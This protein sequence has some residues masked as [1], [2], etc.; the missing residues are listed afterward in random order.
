MTGNHPEDTGAQ[1]SAI[2]ELARLVAEVGDPDIAINELR[3]AK[4]GA[5]IEV[6][7]E[8]TLVITET[9]RRTAEQ[10]GA[11]TRHAVG[12]VIV[13]ATLRGR[14]AQPVWGAF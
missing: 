9:W 8:D 2:Q 7:G 10:V 6:F 5:T 3:S 13:S 1:L 4:E 11:Q 14:K 12:S